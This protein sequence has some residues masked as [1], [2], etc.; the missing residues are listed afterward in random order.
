MD[1]VVSQGRPE[2]RLAHDE[3]VSNGVIGDWNVAKSHIPIRG[4][5]RTWGAND[6]AF[7]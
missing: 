1:G 6:Y 7:C 2:P 4:L 3:V 5:L